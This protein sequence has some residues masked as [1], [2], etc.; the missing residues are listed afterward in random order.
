MRISESVRCYVNIPVNVHATPTTISEEDNVAKK[1]IWDD[2]E[3][4]AC[5]IDMLK[6]KSRNENPLA[7]NTILNKLKDEHK[8]ARIGIIRVKDR[9]N[10]LSNKGMIKET[11]ETHPR[12]YT[13]QKRV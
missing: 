13:E 11:S 3:L 12:Y 1:I 6:R 9:L 8:D 2:G 7:P 5:I 4:D 10:R